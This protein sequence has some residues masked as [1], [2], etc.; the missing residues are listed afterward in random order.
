MGILEWAAAI[1]TAGTLARRRAAWDRAPSKASPVTRPAPPD[2][3][4]LKP[5]STGVLVAALKEVF[6]RDSARLEMERA[7]IDA[8]RRRAEELLRA[9]LRRQAADRMLAQLRLVAVM[10][11][12]TWA[13]SAVLGVLMPGMRE[14]LPRI[15]LGAGWVFALAALGSAF[16]AWQHVSLHVGRHHQRGRR[17]AGSRRGDVCSMAAHHR[18]RADRRGSTGSPVNSAPRRHRRRLPRRSVLGPRP[19]RRARPARR[20]ARASP[21]P[22]PSASSATARRPWR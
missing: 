19:A 16:A 9:E 6:D 22:K 14:G 10:A 20:S 17:R 4:R 21:R 5:D 3:G 13:L 18:A 15:L 12:G 7:Q 11:V 2:P 8:E 1:D